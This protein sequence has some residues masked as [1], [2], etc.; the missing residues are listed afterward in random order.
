MVALCFL[1]CCL[2]V[3]QFNTVFGIVHSSDMATTAAAF[4]PARVTGAMVSFNS[5]TQ[6]RRDK[7]VYVR[8]LNSYGGLKAHNSVVYLGMPVC[9]ERCFASVVSSMKASS[10][11][12]GRGG[13]A[14]SSKC[15]KVGEIFEIAAIMNVLVLIGV[16]V[17]FVL[18][19]IEAFFEESE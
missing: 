16:A 19:R 7:V 18:L 9:T 8:G 14:L 1:H 17:G 15:S 2:Q 4:T 5:K 11:G 3:L 13:G 12:K 10:N 6:K